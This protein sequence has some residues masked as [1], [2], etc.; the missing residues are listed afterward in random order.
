ML[1]KLL[2]L[3]TAAL[4]IMACV[5]PAPAEE[6]PVI[7]DRINDPSAGEG[8]AFAEDAPLLEVIFP[9]IL[10]CDAILLRCGGEVWLV[11]CATQGQARRII[12]MCRQLGITRIDRCR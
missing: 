7:I 12:N 2:T 1:R 8:F 5:S 11:D 3:L 10:N 6:A 9:Q 4:L